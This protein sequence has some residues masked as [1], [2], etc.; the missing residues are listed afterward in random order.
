MGKLGSNLQKTMLIAKM[1]ANK[2][3]SSSGSLIVIHSRCAECEYN[4]PSYDMDEYCGQC[5]GQSLFRPRE[6]EKGE[7]EE[8]ALEQ[9]MELLPK[10][11]LE[12][13]TRLL[14]TLQQELD[15]TDMA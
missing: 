12:E 5:D 10:L 8:T 3:T 15:H 1:K 2:D 9:V 6:E 7:A 13:K 11:T 14:Q 4:D